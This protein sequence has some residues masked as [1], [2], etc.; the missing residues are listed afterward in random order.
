VRGYHHVADHADVSDL[1][2]QAR[3]LIVVQDTVC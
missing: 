1:L 3:E 2:A